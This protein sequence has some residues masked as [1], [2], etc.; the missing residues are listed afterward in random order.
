MSS[1]RLSRRTLLKTLGM[2]G[3]ATFLPWLRPRS[4]EAAGIPTRLLLFWS[5]SGVPRHTY[6]FQS[7][8]G[9][10]PTESDFVFPVVRSPLNDIKQ[11]LIVLEN[12]DMVSATVDPT[13]ASNA[14]YAGETHSLAAANRANGDTAGGP[15]IDQYIAKAINAAGP[16]T[17]IPSLSLAAQCDGNVTSNK[18]CTAASNQVISL[19]PNPTAAYKRLFANFMAPAG[20]V[21]TGPTAQEIAAQQQKSVLDLV[22]SDFAAVSPKLSTA[23]RTKMDA[24]ASAVRDL[25]KRLALGGGPGSVVGSSCKDPTTAVV[26][27]SGNKY[28]GDSVLYEKNLDSMGRL[29]QGAFACD[30]TRVALL[31]VGEPFADEWGY[32]SGAWGTSDAHDLIH[33]T[34]FNNAGTLKSNADAMAAILKLHQVECKQFMATIDLLGQIPEADGKTMLDHTIVLWCS[35]I[36]EHGHDVDY[37]PWIVAGG[38]AVGFKPGRYLK[39][40]R[41]N[42]KGTPHNNL[43][44]SIA[45][46]MGV[47]TTTFGNASVCTGPLAG[48]RV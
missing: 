3:A 30:L 31:G 48:L 9:G 12:V 2:T 25:E 19:E 43:F 24:H 20:P 16:V 23:A 39:Y 4:V 38:S 28:P 29:I 15:S 14:H 40:P 5:G 36:G 34:S 37:L 47:N 42:N 35:Q 22:L 33:K 27:G 7:A 11:K 46:A 17:K 8:A 45:Q 10:A 1:S 21:M 41:T 44:V 32:T 13:S 18:V 6:T 26:Q